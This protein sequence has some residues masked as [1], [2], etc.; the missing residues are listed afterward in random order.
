MFYILYSNH[1][2]YYNFIHI[3]CIFLEDY[4]FIF[5]DKFIN[6]TFN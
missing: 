6:Y 3:I 2:K 1:K 4:N 5:L